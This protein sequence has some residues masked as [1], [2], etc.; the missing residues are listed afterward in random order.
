M[1]WK[2]Q[3]AD[4][5]LARLRQKRKKTQV[6]RVKNENGSITTDTTEENRKK[7][8]KP[9]IVWFKTELIKIYNLTRLSHE[10]KDLNS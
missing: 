2:L 1:F 9:E 4:K 8:E 6:D 7:N 5:P 3:W 10:F